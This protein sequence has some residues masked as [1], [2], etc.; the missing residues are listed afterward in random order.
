MMTPKS[1][2]LLL[3]SC[4]AAIA[5]VGSVFELASGTPKFGSGVTLVILA[6]SIPSV[7]A[8]FYAAVKDTNSVE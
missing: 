5:A 6:L 1:G 3:V 4:V 7:I 2:V 8:A